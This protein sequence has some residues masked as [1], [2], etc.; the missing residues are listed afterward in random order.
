MGVA[1][2]FRSAPLTQPLREGG[3][4]LSRENGM[5]SIRKFAIALSML[6]VASPALCDSLGFVVQGSSITTLR[7]AGATFTQAIGIN[8]LGQV[9]GYYSTNGGA[10]YDGSPPRLHSISASIAVCHSGRS[11]SFFGCFVM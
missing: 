10:G 1:C 4:M 11:D 3:V 2:M 9:V 7:P 8:D 6:A 5:I